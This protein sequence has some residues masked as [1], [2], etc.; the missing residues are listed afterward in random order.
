MLLAHNGNQSSSQQTRHLDV[1]YYFVTDKITKGEIQVEHCG[2]SHMIGDYFTKPLL[3]SLFKKFQD[4]VLN[5]SA[6]STSADP[7]ECVA[8]GT[9]ITKGPSKVAQG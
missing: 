8:P 6:G 4:L 1:R 5:V 3:G 9:E 7:K 2:S